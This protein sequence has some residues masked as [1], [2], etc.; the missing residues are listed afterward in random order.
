MHLHFRGAGA[1]AAH[2]HGRLS[3]SDQTDE[4]FPPQITASRLIREANLWPRESARTTCEEGG[5]QIFQKE[6]GGR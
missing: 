1:T 4:I 6:G 5:G 3:A 2:H